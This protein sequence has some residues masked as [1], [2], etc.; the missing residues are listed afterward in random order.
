MQLA[1]TT[2]SEISGPPLHL[3]GVETI[4]RHELLTTAAGNQE[5]S[6]DAYCEWLRSSSAW[7]GGP[8]IVALS[9]ALRRPIFVYELLQNASNQ[10][11]S[12]V[13]ERNVQSESDD[14]GRTG[15]FE[16]ANI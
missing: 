14:D 6:V 10:S 12:S 7:G 8:E 11:E 1:V 4:P 2:L 15:G 16:N 13:I 9:N 3:E 5:L